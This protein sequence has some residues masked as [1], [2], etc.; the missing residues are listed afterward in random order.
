MTLSEKERPSPAPYKSR[1]RNKFGYHIIAAFAITYAVIHQMVLRIMLRTG[2]FFS[3]I[4]EASLT[5]KEKEALT[6]RLYGVATEKYAV[7]SRLFDWE[8][9]WYDAALPAAPARILITAA[10]RGREVLALLERGYSVDAAEPLPKF[11]TECTVLPGVGDVFAADHDDIMDAVFS[12]KGPAAPLHDLTY[13][14]V[15]VGWGS[16]AHMI[17][18]E[19]RRQFIRACHA[20]SPKGPIL[21]SFFSHLIPPAP[22]SRFLHWGRAAGR[23]IA[24]LRGVAT[25]ID[26]DDIFL[27]HA[28][29]FHRFS[30]E[31]IEALAASAGRSATF[32]AG[33]YGH[34]TLLPPADMSALR[35]MV[36]MLN[37]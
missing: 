6:L 13:D 29:F 21:L 27:W 28:G 17:D 8:V 36:D 7:S 26:P 37:L 1:A 20:L 10:G 2:H 9:P 15:I 3:G 34:A 22:N 24:R 25:T 31:E 11:V 35:K 5:N 12:G 16:L 23:G 18:A 33:P 14:A 32:T 19:K 30:E 4:L